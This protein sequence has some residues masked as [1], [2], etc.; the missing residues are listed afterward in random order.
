MKIYNLL[1]NCEIIREYIPD[2]CSSCSYFCELKTSDNRYVYIKYDTNTL[3]VGIGNN[4]NV[5]WENL[6]N[7]NCEILYYNVVSITKINLFKILSF[8]EKF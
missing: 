1:C 7:N 2:K 3:F 5:F 4:K 6:K 8:F